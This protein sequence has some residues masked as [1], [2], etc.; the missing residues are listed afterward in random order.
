MIKETYGRYFRKMFERA[1][2][3]L[4]FTRNKL[5]KAK[6]EFAK[7]DMAETVH[8]SWIVF[9]NCINIIKDAKNNK[10]L[11]EHKSKTDVFALYHSLG[12]LKNDFSGTFAVLEKLRIR[13]DFGNYSNAPKLPQ[14]EK[15]KNFLDKAVSLF[16]ETEQVLATLKPKQKPKK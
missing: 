9:E 4:E 10:P 3:N 2:N 15:I 6:E 7:G 12:Y 14:K 16:N 13:A 1:K 5:K 11:Y 8:Y